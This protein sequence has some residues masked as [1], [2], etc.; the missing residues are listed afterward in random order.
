MHLHEKFVNLVFLH[1]KEYHL[2]KTNQISFESR[3][4]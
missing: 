4:L 2:L 1:V 3:R